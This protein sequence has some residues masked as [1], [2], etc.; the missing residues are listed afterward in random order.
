MHVQVGFFWHSTD[1]ARTQTEYFDMFI[2]GYFLLEIIINF[3][4]GVW[5]EG[6]YHDRY[7]SADI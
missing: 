4:I 7:F 5:F 6:I 3:Y 2:D 1:C